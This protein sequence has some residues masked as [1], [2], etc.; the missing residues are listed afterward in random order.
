MRVIDLSESASSEAADEPTFADM[1][2]STGSSLDAQSPGTV[3]GAL[4]ERL[5]DGGILETG[6][7]GAPLLR[8]YTHPSCDYC[9]E[10]AQD[11]LERLRMDFIAPGKL[12]LQTMIVPLQKYPSSATQAAALFCAAK[13][14]RGQE[15]FTTL[16][17]TPV[18]DKARLAKIAKPFPAS[19][20]AC[21]TAPDTKAVLDVQAKM[22]SETQVTL[23]PTFT[24]ND[25]RQVGLPKYADLRGWIEASL[26]R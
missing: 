17:N 10:F 1:E 11:Q 21:L 26:R 16:M 24:L 6:L 4:L 2:T 5:A 25:Q 20:T 18:L 3:S 19:F 13:I 7:R 8:I 23:V 9:R 12:R 15:M 22:I 14:G